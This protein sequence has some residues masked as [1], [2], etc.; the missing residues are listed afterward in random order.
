MSRKA[1]KSAEERPNKRQCVGARPE[2]DSR[3][4]AVIKFDDINDDV[5]ANIMSFLET[6][7][8]NDATFISRRF[9]E[10][11]NHPSLDQTRTATIV[12]SSENM[13]VLDLYEK[14]ASRGWTRAFA[15]NSK[16]TCLKIV[17]LERLQQIER[18]YDDSRRE[19]AARSR[20]YQVSHVSTCRLP[21]TNSAELKFLFM[22]LY[23]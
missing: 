5:L 7:E 1:E 18:Y 15:E 4:P 21:T 20:P 12:I 13:T 10:A 3:A 17:G 2:L 23:L 16:I 11:R 22:I 6:K 9:C 14:I 8:L 19:Q